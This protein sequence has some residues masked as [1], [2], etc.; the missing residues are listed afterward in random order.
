MG[1]PD[2][3]VL[4]PDNSDKGKTASHPLQPAPALL[5]APT[6]GQ[7]FNALQ[8]D[9]MAVACLSLHVILFDFDSSVLHPDAAAILKDLSGLREKHRGPSGALPLLSIFGHA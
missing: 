3:P 4:P 1:S 5:V 2:T 6:T 9:L 8:M 7:E